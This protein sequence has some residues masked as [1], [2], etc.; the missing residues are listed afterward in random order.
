VYPFLIHFQS[1]ENQSSFDVNLAKKKYLLKKT[2][3]TCSNNTLLKH[4]LQGIF[5]L[6]NLKF[7]Y[8]K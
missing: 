1:L 4:F 3:T 5:I 8:G 7:L 6:A 2:Y